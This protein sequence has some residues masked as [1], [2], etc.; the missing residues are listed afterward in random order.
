MLRSHRVPKRYHGEGSQSGTPVRRALH[1]RKML[2]RE[3][4]SAAQRLEKYCFAWK[5][6]I[7]DFPAEQ[8]G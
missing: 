7:V 5:A 6:A 4:D 3:T 1:D 8:I 2:S